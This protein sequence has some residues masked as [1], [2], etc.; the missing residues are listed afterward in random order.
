MHAQSEQNFKSRALAALRRE[1]RE[2]GVVSL[3]L[4]LYFFALLMYKDSVLRE[5]GMGYA[6]YGLAIIKALVIGKFVLI[7]Q[8]MHVGHRSHGM[9]LIW[10]LL[11]KVVAFVAL[12][13]ALTTVEDVTLSLLHHHSLHE[14][15]AAITA[16]PWQQVAASSLLGCL[17][18]APFFGF[19]E[20]V[21]AMGS[22]NFRRMMFT[23]RS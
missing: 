18:L 1:L 7:G 6:P 22:E 8:A 14:A 9:A 16:Q 13:Y 19:Q 2:Y 3:Y 5:H 12:L 23:R 15:L 11:H 10:H 20:I 21:D 17:A 4:Y